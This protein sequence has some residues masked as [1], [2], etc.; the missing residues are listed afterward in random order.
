MENEELL[1]V[2]KKSFW[3]YVVVAF[4]LLQYWVLFDK[5]LNGI[6][7]NTTQDL[8]SGI[9]LSGLCWWYVWKKLDRKPLIGSVIGIVVYL[10]LTFVALVLANN[11]T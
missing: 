6:K 10:M 9:L 2:K 7:V 8:G 4:I 5:A 1:N 3:F 11:N